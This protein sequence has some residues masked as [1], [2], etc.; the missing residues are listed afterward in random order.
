MAVEQ[1]IYIVG[2]I[3][4]LGPATVFVINRWS[5]LSQAEIR[6]VAAA[7]FVAVSALLLEVES[8]VTQL[9][10]A[11]G[12]FVPGIALICLVAA[13]YLLYRGLRLR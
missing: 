3:V 10:S 12:R 11:L 4:A 2:A 5:N 9:E 13:G 8:N 7:W 6:F 1:S